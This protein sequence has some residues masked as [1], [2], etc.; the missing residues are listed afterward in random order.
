MR[1]DDQ[2][3]RPDPLHWIWY[4]FGGTLSRATASG[5]ATS[6]VAPGWERQI[7]RAVVQ[8]VPL[9]VALL[10]VWDPGGSPG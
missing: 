9:A 10:L 3:R 1:P 4:T 6:P 8:V 2:R 5:C 7:V